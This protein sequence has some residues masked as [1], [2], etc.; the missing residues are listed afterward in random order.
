MA[1]ERIPPRWKRIRAL[2]RNAQLE[3]LLY[4]NLY[5]SGPKEARIFEII[6]TAMNS[7]GD[8]GDLVRG[9]FSELG[10]YSRRLH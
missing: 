10:S 6:F 1:G 7:E 8:L 4:W 5:R 3:L 9:R 2:D